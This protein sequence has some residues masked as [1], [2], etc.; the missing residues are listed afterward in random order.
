LP[1]PRPAP[2]P[3]RPPVGDCNTLYR[4][5]LPV[6]RLGRGYRWRESDGG[7]RCSAVDAP[8]Y[9]KH[10]RGRRPGTSLLEHT[11]SVSPH[12]RPIPDGGGC[13]PLLSCQ[14][15]NVCVRVQCR[16]C[17]TGCSAPRA[18]SA[19]VEYPCAAQSIH[20]GA[21][22]V[23][24]SSSRST[25]SSSACIAVSGMGE[26][27]SGTTS[28]VKGHRGLHLT[29][30]LRRTTKQRW[31]YSEPSRSKRCDD[32]TTNSS[33]FCKR[34]VLSVCRQANLILRTGSLLFSARW[35]ADSISCG[36]SNNLSTREFMSSS[37][38]EDLLDT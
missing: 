27:S 26:Q 2:H 24:D 6:G 33:S 29:T 14:S 11:P 37:V 19:H 31:E 1:R 3:P 9:V 5:N 22:A 12:A 13:L 15:A 18:K 16:Y 20:D 36:W 28:L 35:N 4:G 30:R 25:T 23:T 34:D 7:E 32:T 38:S 17:R 21:S 8:G 10:R